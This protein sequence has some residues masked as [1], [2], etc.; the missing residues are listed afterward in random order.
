MSLAHDSPE[1][2]GAN[3]AAAVKP[4]DTGKWTSV[5]VGLSSSGEETAN[6][7]S[8][9][10]KGTSLYTVETLSSISCEDGSPVG[11]PPTHITAAA[12]G[13]CVGIDSNLH[14]FDSSCSE[15][16]ASLNLGES[17]LTE[18]GVALRSRGLRQS[19]LF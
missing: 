13:L 10:E 18:P 4:G 8:R 7:G 1:R 9:K 6:F 19:V 14:L 12:D 2:P 3:A 16:K 17:Y 11:V 5:M 15:L